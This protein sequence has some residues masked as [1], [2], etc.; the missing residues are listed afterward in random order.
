MVRLFRQGLAREERWTTLLRNRMRRIGR[1]AGREAEKRRRRGKKGKI[2]VSNQLRDEAGRLACKYWE[3]LNCRQSS[4]RLSQFLQV[5]PSVT[6]SC[7]YYFY[8]M[9]IKRQRQMCLK[10]TSESNRIT[11][12]PSWE[13]KC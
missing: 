1:T 12:C 13:G 2:K 5:F 3:T 4:L 10:S 11:P 7:P 8:S 9:Q 6:D